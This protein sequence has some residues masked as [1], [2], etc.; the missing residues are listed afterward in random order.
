MISR[1]AAW[2]LVVAGVFNVVIWPRFGVAIW[3]DERAWTGAVGDSSP[4][5]FL[6][7]HVVLI[8]A[9]VAIALGVLWVAF[10]ALRSRRGARSD[11]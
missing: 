10:T 8:G 7:V 2:F 3:N 6:W 11:H 5:S 1:G 9:A 4:T